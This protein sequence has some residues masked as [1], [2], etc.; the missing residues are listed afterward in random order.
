MKRCLHCGRKVE[1]ESE[2]RDHY[3]NFHK[4]DPSNAFFKKLFNTQANQLINKNCSLSSDF[5][6]TLNYKKA[7][8][9]VK[10]YKEGKEGLVKDKPLDI[11]K[12]SPS[13]VKYQISYFKHSN[14][15]N[16][17]NSEQVVNEFLTNVKLHFKPA[18]PVQIKASF[19]IENY[20][21]S[22]SE[23]HP[24]LYNTRY[25]STDVYPANYF[26]SFVYHNLRQDITMRVIANGLSGSSWMFSKF[27][28][29]SVSV[30]KNSSKLVL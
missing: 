29:L 10:H 5:L 22:I 3:I 4:V 13:I 1:T 16:F 19:T 14:D 23:D 18:G 21:P 30:Y 27:L 2:L 20:Q 12:S 8:D 15:Y 7:H 26:N 11:I 28:N 24:P 9:F 25:W 6:T 17:S